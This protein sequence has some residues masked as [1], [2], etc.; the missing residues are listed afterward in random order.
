M[1]IIAGSRKGA[2]IAAPRGDATR[3]TGD[4]AREAAFNLIGPLEGASVLDLFAG[5]GAMGLEALSR[6][7]G[8]VVFVERERAAADTI[9]RNLDTLRLTGATVL[10]SDALRALSAEA[11]AGRRYDLVLV[12]PPYRALSSLLPSLSA[13]L[14]AVVAPEGL[15]V[16]E[17]DA[18]EQP[19]LPL[20][21]YTSR[22]Y[23]S[24]R[25]T[26]FTGR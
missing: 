18:R 14:P 15:V 21:V 8:H 20:P 10:R 5:S 2:R 19:E 9:E 11:A 12:D 22:R 17:S 4:R 1:R 7:A 23:G 25:I 26:V 3:P 6:G 16:V 24:A 13:Y